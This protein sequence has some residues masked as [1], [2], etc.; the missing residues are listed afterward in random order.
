MIANSP[1]LRLKGEHLE[2]LE[3]ERQE[4]FHEAGLSSLRKGDIIGAGSSEG[5][6]M[7]LVLGWVEKNWKLDQFLLLGRKLFSDSQRI[8]K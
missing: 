3:L 1:A 2:F 7:Q 4:G 8:R 6:S 5:A